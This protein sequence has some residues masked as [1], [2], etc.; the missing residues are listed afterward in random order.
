[1]CRYVHTFVL[2]LIADSIRFCALTFLS[3]CCFAFKCACP[4]IL[5][6]SFGGGSLAQGLQ[7]SGPADWASLHPAVNAA[8][9]REEQIS[10]INGRARLERDTPGP[11]P[12]AQHAPVGE[13]AKRQT[14]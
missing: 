2:S 11:D 6:S 8:E 14:C 4:S 10:V 12:C 3:S 1:M 13:T 7:Q 9:L 5:Q